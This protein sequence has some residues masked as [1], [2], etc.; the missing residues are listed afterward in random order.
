[1]KSAVPDS[2]GGDAAQRPRIGII[3]GWGRYPIVIVDAL[4][5]QGY[6]VY[7]LGVSG[8]A[9]KD[10]AD[11]CVKFAW[12]GFGR[13]G[14]AARFFRRHGVHDIMMAGKIHKRQLFQPGFILRTIPGP[15]TI[16][17][18][19]PHFLTRRKDNRD[20]S[21][22]MTIINFFADRGIRFAPPTDYLPELLVKS[23]NLTKRTPSEAQWKDIRFGWEIAR[24]MGR[25]DVGQSVAVKNQAV[26]AV[27]AIEGTDENIRRAGLLC[28]GGF[29]V[30]KVAKPN[31][32]MRFDVP[33]IGLGTVEALAESG[34]KVLAVEAEKTVFVDRDAT[35]EYANK[36]GLVLVAIKEEELK[37]K[38]ASQVT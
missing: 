9:D 2:S 28:R 34:G 30:V 12:F 17:L 35:V 36:K 26:F 13:F 18:F 15:T 11:R 7:G 4:K 1:M 21:I 37:E 14:S 29:T 33:T 23:E 25:L 5:R 27:E 3:A 16:R 6:D 38:G 19:T 24:E 8:H 20:D 31:Q 22:L 32:D 10:L